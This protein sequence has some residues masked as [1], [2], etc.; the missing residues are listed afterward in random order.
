M[1]QKKNNNDLSFRTSKKP[2]CKHTEDALDQYFATLNGDRPG[3]LYELVIGEVERPL[4]Q[5]VMDYTQGNQSQ[6]AGIL[7]INRGTLRKKLR[8]YSI[9]Q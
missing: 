3:D 7:G 9:I 8:T 5:A 2:L 1:A 6:A 4:F